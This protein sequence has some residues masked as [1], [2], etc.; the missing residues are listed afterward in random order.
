MQRRAQLAHDLRAG[1]RAGEWAPGAMVPSVMALV[2]RYEVSAPVVHEEI[3]KLVDEGILYAVP[4]VGTFVSQLRAPSEPF[5]F[6]WHDDSAGQTHENRARRG[7]E[8][9]IAA[10]GGAVLSLFADEAQQ[11]FAS[12]Q[13]PAIA[14]FF[15]FNRSPLTGLLVERGVPAVRFGRVSQ[16]EPNSDTVHFDDVDGGRKATEHLLRLGHQ[17]VAF[18]G[19]HG[20]GETGVFRWSRA[21]EQGWRAAMQS[22]GHETA[23]LSFHPALSSPLPV[24]DQS[25]IASEAAALLATRSNITAV[26]A[27]NS[28]AARGTLNA[29]SQAG[30]PARKWPALVCFDEIEELDEHIISA[31]ALPWEEVGRQAAGL[32]WQRAAQQ[33]HGA[34]QQRLVPMKLIPRLSCRPDWAQNT[35]VM[36]KHAANSLGTGPV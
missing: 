18:V 7:F 11:D 3:R 17:R 26:V 31:L 6:L 25:K 2:K 8:E 15:E 5:L 10:R 36:Q 1:C 22:A 28:Y 34:G 16:A 4:R 9:E 19:L 24:L 14:G 32:L 29:L 23:G 12:G 13:W 20:E 33:L 35:R 21:R 30:V 27:A